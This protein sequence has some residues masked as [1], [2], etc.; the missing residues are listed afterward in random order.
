MAG[1]LDN[2]GGF[3]GLLG[4][5][6]DALDQVAYPGMY[7]QQRLMQMQQGY[8]QK[9]SDEFYRQMSM[10]GQP[11]QPMSAPQ[12][13]LAPQP[14]MSAPQQPQFV[15]A[16]PPRPVPT[17]SADVPIGTTMALP[18]GG[19]GVAGG[20]VSAER[21]A[22]PDAKNPRSS[23]MGDGQFISSTWLDVVRRN[24]PDLAARPDSELLAMRADPKLSL[25]M[26]DAYARENGTALSA[27]GLQV[28]PG[29]Q[30]L[31]HFA[32][33][34]GAKA[35]LNAP[36]D[37]SAGGILGP[38]VVAANPF[39]AGMTA[40]DLIAWADRKMG[41]SAQPAVYRPN[42]ENLVQR[43][44]YDGAPP[45]V[46]MAQNNA[47]PPNAQPAQGPQPPAMQPQ[48]APQQQPQGGLSPRVMG[49]IRLMTMPNITPGQK[50]VVTKLFQNELDQGK[51]TE[52]QKNYAA[53]LAGGYQGSF[54]DY[55]HQPSFGPIGKDDMGNEVSGWRNPNTLATIVPPLP[56]S[57]AQG[58]PSDEMVRALRKEIQDLPSYKNI[59]QSAPVYKS[60]VDAAGRDNRAADVNLIYG[61]AKIMDP[62]S[63]VRESEMTI[64]QAVAT[65]PQHMQA[66]IMSQLQATGRL[67]PEVRA[68]IMQ[69]AYSRVTAYKGMFD[70]DASQF[71]GIAERRRM[72]LADVIPDFGEF[73]TWA[74]QKD[75]PQEV[76]G[77]SKGMTATNPKTGAKII[78]DGTKWVPAQGI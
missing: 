56:P 66:T 75:K 17:M 41:G 4:G 71:K 58:K 52:Q 50:E 59:A 48:Q 12:P 68:G 6:R 51:L 19:G 43:P 11:P 53:A 74:P 7:Q 2:V 9:A 45:P 29:T 70:Q 32:G 63:V 10:Y 60:M 44:V 23:A 33:P 15:P 49:L 35:I 26:T 13:Q 5:L 16:Q 31:A 36:P 78:F 25:E 14:M 34:T 65:L 62:G 47:L 30:Y 69:E 3:Q 18:I 37:A 22:T 27:A 46:Q 42:G 21:G 54:A 72:N 40:R 39:L 67:S 20:I 64:A 57:V 76:P 28:T 73:K 55:Q 24:R 77:L 38:K 1:L 61:F 8:Q